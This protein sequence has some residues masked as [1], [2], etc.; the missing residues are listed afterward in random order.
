[1]LCKCHWIVFYIVHFTAFCLGVPFFPGHG[2]L[3][4]NITGELIVLWFH[5]YIVCCTIV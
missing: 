5:V 1:M 3:L 2:V 4:N